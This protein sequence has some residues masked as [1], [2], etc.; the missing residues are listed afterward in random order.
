LAEHG[1][2]QPRSL[3]VAFL[4]PVSELDDSGM[5]AASIK[6]LIDTRAKID[7]AYG[8]TSAV[9]KTMNVLDGQGTLAEILAFCRE[10]G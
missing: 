7:A 10:P 9:E 3:A 1:A 2:A 4:K 8:K 6:A 5:M